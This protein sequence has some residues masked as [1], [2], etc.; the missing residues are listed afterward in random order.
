M[1]GEISWD[2]LQGADIMRKKGEGVIFPGS[3]QI[4]KSN[5]AKPAPAM[6]MVE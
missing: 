1:S 2:A 4:F 5:F 3:V 6:V